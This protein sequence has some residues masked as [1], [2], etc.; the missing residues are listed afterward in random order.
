MR[1]VRPM[2]EEVREYF[3]Y[4]NDHGNLYHLIRKEDAWG[5]RGPP[6]GPAHLRDGKFLN[7]FFGLLKENTTGLH[8]QEFPWV[9][10]CKG[11]R[12]FLRSS[13]RPIVYTSLEYIDEKP[14]LTY[15]GGGLKVLFDPTKLAVCSLGRIYYPSKVGGMGLLSCHLAMKVGLEDIWDVDGATDPALLW[16]GVEYPLVKIQ[17]FL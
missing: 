15:G 10:R 7:F 3:Y 11:E 8:E 12:N 1:R 17:P 2:L 13:D 9:S 4:V 6:R 16:E 5:P 14:Y